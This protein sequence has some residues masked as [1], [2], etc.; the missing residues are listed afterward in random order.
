MEVFNK[1]SV[2]DEQISP[3][4]KQ[5]TAIRKEHG[6][7]MMAS[8]TFLSTA[9]GDFGRSDTLIN[10]VPNRRDPTLSKAMSSIRGG[11]HETYT[12]TLSNDVGRQ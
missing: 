9:D 7:P 6:I 3:L 4:L 1:E 2:Y 12:V 5:I 8:F 10:D 11:N